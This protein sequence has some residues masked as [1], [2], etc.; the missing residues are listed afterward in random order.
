MDVANA[1]RQQNL[2]APSGQIGQLP[3]PR[4][5]PFQL[6]IDTAGPAVDAGAVR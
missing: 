5:Q 2:D 1:V 4:G 3:A 6:P